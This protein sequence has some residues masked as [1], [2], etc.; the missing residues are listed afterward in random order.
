MLFTLLFTTRSLLRTFS[1]LP[2]SLAL[3]SC[4]QLFKRA[5][6]LGDNEAMYVKVGTFH[7]STALKKLESSVSTHYSV[8]VYK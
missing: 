3:F 7:N 8:Y 5:G 1:L 4:I 6:S 2:R